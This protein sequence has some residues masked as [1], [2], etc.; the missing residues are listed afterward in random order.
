MNVDGVVNFGCRFDG[1]AEKPAMMHLR[2]WH[3]VNIGV[4][5][6]RTGVQP[7][8]VYCMLLVR[9]VRRSE[10]VRVL[11]CFSRL[12]GVSYVLDDIDMV[13]SGE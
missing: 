3:G 9:P 7:S 10:A 13:L 12:V 11:E 5:A 8:L 6:D 4:L 2:E 1:D